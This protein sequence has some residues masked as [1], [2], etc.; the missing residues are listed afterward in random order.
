MLERRQV[1]K[2]L[3]AV[4]ATALTM[5]SSVVLADV[6]R[7]M[8]WEKGIEKLFE[9]GLKGQERG[10]VYVIFGN[11]EGRWCDTTAPT[12]MFDAIMMKVDWDSFENDTVSLG[13]AK[14]S[15]YTHTH[16]PQR[17]EWF[18]GRMRKRGWDE[19]L[20]QKFVCAPPSLGDIFAYGSD[21]WKKVHTPRKRTSDF[22]NAGLV[23]DARTKDAWLF[24]PMNKAKLVQLLPELAN[25]KPIEGSAEFVEKVLDERFSFAFNRF[26]EYSANHNGS[27]PDVLASNLGQMLFQKLRL[28]YAQLGFYVRFIPKD[29][30][31][32]LKPSD[33]LK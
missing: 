27:V 4:G 15:I 3:G 23:L 19:D 13:E 33:L 28:N 10:D 24:A 1:L 8:S 26:C 11:D 21:E 2:G 29:E 18:L 30:L 25:E 7:L 32:K 14:N 6:P 31:A 9:D 17:L 16:P 22:R 5:P 12:R 20:L